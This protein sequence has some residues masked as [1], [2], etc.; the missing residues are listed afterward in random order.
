ML[1]NVIFKLYRFWGRLS[2][3]TAVVDLTPVSENQ[4]IGCEFLTQ[5]A[6]QVRPGNII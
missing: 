2:G 6:R 3:L 1:L 4:E 5:Q